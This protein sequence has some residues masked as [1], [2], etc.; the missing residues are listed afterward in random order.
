MLLDI[1]LCEGVTAMPAIN[2]SVSGLNQTFADGIALDILDK[3]INQYFSGKIALVSSFGAESVVLLH[4][5][6]QIDPQLPIIFL[7][8]EFHFQETLD[9]QKMVAAELGLRNVVSVSPDP[10][11]IVEYDQNGDLHQS[12][13]D[14]C[15]AL[16]KTA[17]LETAVAGYDAWITGRKRHQSSS[18]ADLELFEEDKNLKI[19]VNPLAY[20]AP[21]QL[22]RYIVDHELPRHPLVKSGYL[23]VGCQPCTTPVQSGED[24]RSG[25]WRG[26]NKQECGI[27]IQGGKI[28]RATPMTDQNQ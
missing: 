25:R 12:N 5:V 28:V 23:S 10:N 17:P 11:S 13:K 14:Q 9:Y 26:A 27:H 8:T 3:S 6:S 4:L 20:W 21:Q 22:K 1:D 24:P 7:D 15:C 19:K 18:R 2:R 16:R